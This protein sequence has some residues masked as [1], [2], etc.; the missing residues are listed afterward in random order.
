MRQLDYAMRPI[1]QP[2]TT[3]TTT[4]ITQTKDQKNQEQQQKNIAFSL[5]SQFNSGENESSM[6]MG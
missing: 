5:L 4:A 3:T 1:S 6:T 2:R